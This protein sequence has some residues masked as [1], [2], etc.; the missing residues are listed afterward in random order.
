[1]TSYKQELVASL[2]KQIKGARMIFAIIQGTDDVFSVYISKKEALYI[3]DVFEISIYTEIEN[4]VCWTYD[5][6]TKKLSIG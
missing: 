6:K 4:M 2:R 3:V 1:M 5:D